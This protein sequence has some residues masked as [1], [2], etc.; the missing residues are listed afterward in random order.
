MFYESLIDNMEVGK[1]YT[2]NKENLIFVKNMILDLKD[3]LEKDAV[4]TKLVKKYDLEPETSIYLYEGNLIGENVLEIKS[5]EYLFPFLIDRKLYCYGTNEVIEDNTKFYYKNFNVYSE[6]YL[7]VSGKTII[8][9][10]LPNEIR[11]FNNYKDFL[12]FIKLEIEN[13]KKE[14]KKINK[15]YSDEDHVAYF[16][17]IEVSLL[18]EML[19]VSF[20]KT[21]DEPRYYY[22]GWKDYIKF[23][24]VEEYKYLKTKKF[25]N[26]K[27]KIISK[28]LKKRIYQKEPEKILYL[29]KA[30]KLENTNSIPYFQ[31]KNGE[32]IFP[33]LENKKL[34]SE[35]NNNLIEDLTIFY[36]KN[37]KIYTEEEIK[38]LY[39]VP[40]S[41]IR[42]DIKLWDKYNIRG[43]RNYFDFFDFVNNLITE[44]KIQK[45]DFEEWGKEKLAIHFYGTQLNNEKD[46][47]KEIKK[48][49]DILKKYFR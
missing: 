18:R 2:I 49:R 1:S 9:E 23:D 26:D 46:C 45:I 11:T 24:P 32:R 43:F 20:R 12:E 35:I 16:K 36:Y 33:F 15:K 34:Y 42:D 47:K 39:K 30:I 44:L 3:D 40:N 8:D 22:V 25:S 38:V 21:F 14:I 7:D 13:C 27:T 19:R 4:L 48:Y 28:E 6:N 5:K 10:L 41:E 17:E 37:F 31:I 29:W